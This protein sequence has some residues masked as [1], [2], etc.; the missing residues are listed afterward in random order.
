MPAVT[1]DFRSDNTSGV[2]PQVLDAIARAATGAANPYGEDEWTARLTRTMS[3]VFETDVLVFPVATGTAANTLALA[4]LTPPFGAVY[5]H[6]EAHVNTDECGAPEMATGGAKLVGIEGEHGRIA[7]KDLERVLSVAP[8]G[9]HWV[10]PSALTLSQSTES[11]TIYQP[12]EIAAL[13]DIAHRAGLPVHLDGARFANALARLGCTPA[14]ATWKAGIDVMSFGATKNGALAAEAVVFFRP[15]LAAET[16]FRRKRAGH[17]VSKMRFISAQ[18]EAW[19]ADGLWL[20][21]AGHANAMADRLSQGLLHL[22]GTALAHPVQANEIFVHLPEAA[23]TAA[24]EAGFGFYTWGG[25]LIRLVT[26]F[27]TPAAEVDRFIAIA[28]A[29]LA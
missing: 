28:K 15:E 6:A 24:Q 1:H 19:L 12:A 10:K 7:P 22:P 2:A 20:Q 29:A 26:S 21:L 17:L 11:G 25:D 14:E 13:T 27:D 8:R 16:A 3:A 9:V 18:Y 23:A 4:S 5:C